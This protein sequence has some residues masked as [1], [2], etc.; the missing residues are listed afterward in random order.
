MASATASWL[1]ITTFEL[2]RAG[3]NPSDLSYQK[4]GQR[5]RVMT[6][7]HHILA[8]TSW[9]QFLRSNL[10]DKWP[11]LLIRASSDPPSPALSWSSSQIQI[12]RRRPT[13]P[14]ASITW[15]PQPCSPHSSC[16][17]RPFFPSELLVLYLLSVSPSNEPPLLCQSNPLAFN[18]RIPG[19]GSTAP[20][21][22]WSQFGPSCPWVQIQP[23]ITSEVQKNSH[24]A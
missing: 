20:T 7:Y 14:S 2:K 9:Y 15:W 23:G 10:P 5:Y 4:N 8:Q 11:M 17:F 6:E 12:L 1:S 16:S 24:R 22:P 18:P 3:T 19:R 13:L 21:R